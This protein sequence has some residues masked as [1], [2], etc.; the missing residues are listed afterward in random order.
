PALGIEG[1]DMMDKA[2]DR[3]GKL[4]FGA[5][6]FGALK[7]ALHRACVGKLFEQQDLSLDCDEIY[8]IAKTMVG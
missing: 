4:V 5:L 6:G 7:I 1:I 3:H 8:A 2:K